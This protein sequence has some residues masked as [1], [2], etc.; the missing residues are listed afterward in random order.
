MV[1]DSTITRII[2]E[3]LV[4]DE[5]E[6][7]MFQHS[8]YCFSISMS[9]NT[10]TMCSK[11]KLKL[12][13]TK[14]LTYHSEGNLPYWYVYVYGFSSEKKVVW[15]QTQKFGLTLILAHTPT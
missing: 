11:V 9:C 4:I 2:V 12:I 10:I 7:A 3:R 5:F 8:N 15:P 13:T 6:C 14:T 1:A